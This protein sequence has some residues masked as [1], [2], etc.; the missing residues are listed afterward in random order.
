MSGTLGSNKHIQRKNPSLYERYHED[1]L[2]RKNICT[3]KGW[4]GQATA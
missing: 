4:D 2:D 1:K 3:Q